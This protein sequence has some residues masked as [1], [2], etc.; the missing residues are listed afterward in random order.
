MKVHLIIVILAVS[1][2]VTAGLYVG[3][4]TSDGRESAEVEPVSVVMVPKPRLQ[5]AT[6]VEVHTESESTVDLIDAVDEELIESLAAGPHGPALF[7]LT[8]PQPDT[9]I[10]VIRNH[11]EEYGDQD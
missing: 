9:L 3:D 6:A 10:F 11:E 5:L 8:P 2:A 4:R 7:E 1:V